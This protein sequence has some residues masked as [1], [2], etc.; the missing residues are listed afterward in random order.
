MNF[1][2]SEN[3]SCPEKTGLVRKL[4]DNKFNEKYPPTLGIEYSTYICKI[5]DETIKIMLWDTS[6][7]KN[8]EQISKAYITNAVGGIVTFSLTD[9]QTFE[10]TVSWITLLRKTGAPNVKIVLVGTKSDLINDRQVTESEA[11]TF[12]ETQGIPYFETSAKT[13]TNVQKAFH[14]LFDE[15]LKEM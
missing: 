2:E 7:D 8:F 4:V 10:E 1:S 13:D 15:V 11:Q 12:A 9:C 14:S 3:R 6:G 5:N